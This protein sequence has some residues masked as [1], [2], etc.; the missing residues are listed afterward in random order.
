[1]TP[2]NF[3]LGEH[4]RKRLQDVNPGALAMSNIDLANIFSPILDSYQAQFSEFKSAF[5]PLIAE[6]Q[7][8][9][10][11]SLSSLS[12]WYEEFKRQLDDLDAASPEIKPIFLQAGFWIVPS[13]SWGIISRVKELHDAGE[14]DPQSLSELIRNEYRKNDHFILRNAIHKWFDN[15]L[16]ARR[17]HI[18]SDALEAHVNGKYSLS[19]PALLAQIEGIGCDLANVKHGKPKKT[20]SS[21][22]EKIDPALIP[23]I[24]KDVLIA[25]ITTMAY[26]HTDKLAEDGVPF[27]SILQRHAILHGMTYTYATEENSLRAFFLLDSFSS[28][29]KTS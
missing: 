10:M 1:M 25:Y 6:V 22:A 9:I 15:P 5:T 21:V 27:D 11:N 3:D 29:E 4:I 16:F 18:I 7:A 20:L 13:M 17:K 26:E 14:L 23:S 19:I 12:T 8:S 2:A 24:S 28:I